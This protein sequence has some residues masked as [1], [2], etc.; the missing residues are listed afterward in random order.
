MDRRAVSYKRSG[1]VYGRQESPAAQ[2]L[3]FLL[4]RRDDFVPVSH[5]EKFRKRLKNAN[6]IIYESKNGHFKIS[7]FPEIVKMI[8]ADV[9]KK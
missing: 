3:G 7:E 2:S 4:S 6:I 1:R 8:K 9:K 5:A